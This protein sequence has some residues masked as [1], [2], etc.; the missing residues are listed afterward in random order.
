MFD[1]QDDILDLATRPV[2]DDAHLPSRQLRLSKRVFD[3]A[4][5]LLLLP[6][7]GLIAA[8]LLVLNPVFNRG[9]LMHR[10]LR[11]GYAGQPFMAYKFRSMRHVVTHTRGAF[12]RLEEDR[13][14]KLGALMRKCRIDELPQI[15]NVLR[16]EMSL[17]G[18]RPDLF[19]HALAYQQQVPGYAARHKVMPGISGLAQTEIGYVDGLKGIRRKV[20]ADHYYIAHASLRFDLW[21]AWRTL[22]VI[23]GCKGR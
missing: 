15:L 9:S 6:V 20:A 19:D 12:D 14:S 13:I 2:I 16:K 10:Q 3:I 23:A 18:P 1:F 11:M 8:G 7:L 17:I 22:C 21:I 5:S 4:V